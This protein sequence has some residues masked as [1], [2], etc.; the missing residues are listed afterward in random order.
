VADQ[1]AIMGRRRLD[2]LRS[3]AIGWEDLT[4][5]RTAGVARLVGVTPLGQLAAAAPAAG[6]AAS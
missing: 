6:R 1:V 5:R 3:G 2:L 4:Q